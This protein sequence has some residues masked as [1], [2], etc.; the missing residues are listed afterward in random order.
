MVFDHPYTLKDIAEKTGAELIGDPSFLVFGMNEIHN[1][2]HGEL[3]FVDHPKYYTK[4]LQ[5]DAGVVLINSQEVECPKGKALLYHEDPFGAFVKLG[6]Y[7]RKFVSADQHISPTAKIGKGTVIQLGCFIG[8]H[9]KIG[10][11]CT[12]HANVSIYDGVRIGDEVTI[13]SG[14]VIGAD[15]FYFQKKDGNYRKLKS[16][17]SVEIQSYVE[18][19]AGCCIDRGVSADT[20]IGEGTKMDN[21]IQ[22]GHDTCVGRHCLIGAQCAIAG[23]TT[24]E[25]DCII[26]AKVAINKDL[27]IGKGTVIYAY[28]AVDKSCGENST[29]FGIPANNVS[30]EWR[31]KVMLR[32]LPEIYKQLTEK[33]LIK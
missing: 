2:S 20:V 23:V 13:H 17:G 27:V 6:G 7:F 24:I 11:H 25:D 15:A 9:V 28:S 12:I 10:D 16:I 33:G 5:S 4:A 31:K 14:T 21:Q 29:I 18:I 8:E 1:V 3:T 22:I 30:S 32:K 26:W 19:G